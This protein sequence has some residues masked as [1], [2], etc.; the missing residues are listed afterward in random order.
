MNQSRTRILYV[1]TDLKTGGV[2]LHLRRLALAM[3]ARGFEPVVVSLAPS[4]HVAHLLQDDGIPTC[5]CDGRSRW[6]AGVFLR[7]RRIIRSVAPDVVHAFLFHANLAVRVASSLGGFPL[8][9]VLC[10]YQTVEVERLWHLRVERWLHRYCRYVIGNSPSVVDHLARKAKIPARG[11][12]LI[13]GGIDPGPLRRRPAVERAALGLPEEGPL[14]L[15]VG[16]LDPIKGLNILIDAFRSVTRR[17]DAHLI[18]VGDGPLRVRLA[19]QVARAR[20]GKRVHLLGARDDV[21]SLLHAADVFVLP[22]R[23]EGLPN[24]LLE[25][26]AAGCP[27]VAT[28]V[29]G[30]RDLVEHE[31]TGLLVPYGD[32]DALAAALVRLLAERAFAAALARGADEV[33]THKWHISRTYSAYAALYDELLAR[34]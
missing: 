14:V 34:P 4:A 16:R 3:R 33:V 8:D 22:S 10:E 17:S 15:W 26:M 5:S 30:C 19:S 32:T 31:V 27:V 29:P 9:R 18:L 24:A 13:R 7:L 1:I 11:L 6:D 2:P 23:T 20:L 12:R 25:A 28:D 21:A